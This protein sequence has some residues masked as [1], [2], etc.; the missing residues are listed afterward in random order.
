MSLRINWLD[1]VVWDC[2]YALLKQP[3]W[4]EEELSKQEANE[5]VEELQKRIRIEHQRIGQIQVKIRRIQEGYEADPPVYTTSEAEEKI[6]VYHALISRVET[7]VYRL[8]ELMAQQALNKKTKEEAR[9]VLEAMRDMNLE[10]ASF[11]E[12]QNLI[13]KL[14]VK[15]HPSEDKKVVRISSVL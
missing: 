11:S 1:G 7:E 4:V 10:N 3:E 9:R 2:V 15:V 8:Q 6:R 5:H 12:K 14:G 13:A